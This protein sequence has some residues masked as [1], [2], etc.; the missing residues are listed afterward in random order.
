MSFSGFELHQTSH[1]SFSQVLNSC[2][3]W[4]RSV[5]KY[6]L[7]FSVETFIKFVTVI[8]I[9]CR[10]N[11]GVDNTTSG[12]CAYMSL[13]T[14]VPLISFLGLMHFWISFLVFVLGVS[15][16]HKIL[17]MSLYS[18]GGFLEYPE[19]QISYNECS[20]SYIFPNSPLYVPFH[21]S[22]FEEYHPETG[23]R[24]QSSHC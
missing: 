13:H 6:N 1:S 8:D 22:C 9:G 10:C 12:I 3:L 7:F 4:I 19:F 23:Q 24:R 17:H 5:S 11:E 16:S 20:D 21:R 15:G 2:F 18:L 14:M